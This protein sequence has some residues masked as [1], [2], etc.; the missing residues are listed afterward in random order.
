MNLFSPL[1]A[2]I[3]FLVCRGNRVGSV[4]PN[5]GVSHR[6]GERR[7]GDRQQ[8]SLFRRLAETRARL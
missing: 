2:L 6:P 1:T 3:G 5:T 4:E 7:T 8:M